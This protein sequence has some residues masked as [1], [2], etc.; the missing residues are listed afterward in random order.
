MSIDAAAGASSTTSPGAPAR[1]PGDHVVHHVDP[2]LI[3]SSLRW[4]EVHDRDVGR[5]S[6]PAPRRS[7]RGRRRCRT[8]P[9]SRSRAG[10]TSSSS[11]L[12]APLSR[13]PAIHTTLSNDAQRRRRGVRVGGLGVVDEP[14]AV[15]GRD[16][17][18]A[19]RVGTE[20]AQP[21]ADRQRPPR[22]MPEP[23]RQR[24]ARSRRSGAR[25][26]ARRPG[27]RAASPA[28]PPSS[29][30]SRRTRGRPARRRRR[31]SIEIAGAPEGEADRPA[32]LDD[33]GLHDQLLGRRVGDVVDA[34]DLGAARRPG[35]WPAGTPRTSR[36][37][38][39]GPARR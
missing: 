34:R 29:A 8:T 18:D 11:C 22:R 14:D 7:A 35:P 20:G 1:R 27:G 23:A 24:P 5:V 30:G 33:L 2:G 26:S 9:R 32:A 37:S 28:R 25:C 19:V 38:P 21:V 31:P 6:A 17:G 4:T 39:G 16:V 12:V 10:W 15:D 13:P 3:T 36:A